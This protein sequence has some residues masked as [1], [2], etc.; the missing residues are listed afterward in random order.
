M[1]VHLLNVFHPEAL[2]GEGGLLLPILQLLHPL[3]R[4]G[5]LHHHHRQPHHC[6]VGQGEGEQPLDREF[7]A[8]TPT[9]G[10]CS[11]IIFFIITAI[12]LQFA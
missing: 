7:E 5:P 9:A 10:D 8:H 6:A 4:L 1:H 11:I 3:V 12:W 2:P